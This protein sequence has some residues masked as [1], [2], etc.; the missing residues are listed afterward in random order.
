M[1]T[2][3]GPSPTP[4]A[5]MNW[6]GSRDVDWIGG[7]NII[8]RGQR[9][10]E[11][12]ISLLKAP[13]WKI[14]WQGNWDSRTWGVE[15]ATLCPEGGSVWNSAWGHKPNRRRCT[16]GLEERAGQ[17]LRL[18][19]SLP[20]GCL[21]VK[22]ARPGPCGSPRQVMIH[23]GRGLAFTKAEPG[24]HLAGVHCMSQQRRMPAVLIPHPFPSFLESLFWVRRLSQKLC[25]NFLGLL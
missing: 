8:R 18:R 9:F 3:C 23:T 16:P 15:K 24:P 19:R 5:W 17:L 2:W 20:P 7:S 1:H 22:T 14:T 13:L 21:P 25:V 11:K 4:R 6:L 12:E 10:P